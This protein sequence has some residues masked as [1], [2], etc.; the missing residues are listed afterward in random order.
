MAAETTL[1]PQPAPPEPPAPEQPVRR[2]PV[3]G[4]RVVGILLAL[5]LIIAGAG[6]L[7]IQFFQQRTTERTTVSATVTR[8]VA[9]TGTGNV[10]IRAGAAGTDVQVTSELRWSFRKPR[11]DVAASAGTLTVQGDCRPQAW[12]GAW[13]A[14][15]V[16]IAL[17]PGVSLDLRTGTGN[18]RV[19]GA[20]GAVVAESGTG[21]VWLDVPGS[22][23]V[24]TETGLGD[25]TV[26]GGSA[27]A[28]IGAT[29]GTGNIRL[30]LSA[31]PADVVAD[32]GTGSIDVRVP[33]GDSYLVD[34]DTGVGKV[35]VRVP[36]DDTAPRRIV[37]KT[38]TGDITI[39]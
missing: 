22:S 24:R 13:C 18:I 2:G 31:A 3:I 36:R 1:T 4:L 5:A 25:V 9:G 14:T 29:T 17:P 23:T 33:A 30:V 34:A 10:R 8:L 37:A 39:R 6:S 12:A 19:S 20:T 11:V 27:G 32:T 35:Q 15:D 21:D 16:E 38:G 26:T 28:R 7:V